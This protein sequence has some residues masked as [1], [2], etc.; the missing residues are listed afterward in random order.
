MNIDRLQGLIDLYIKAGKSRP[1]VL[2][3][4]DYFMQQEQITQDDFDSLVIALDAQDASQE[5]IDLRGLL[6]ER[7]A[8]RNELENA[9]PA[10]LDPV[11]EEG[12]VS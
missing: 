3:M 4:A 9:Q 6:E 7:D 5:R 12:G 8:L 2:T 1:A 11:L 10:I